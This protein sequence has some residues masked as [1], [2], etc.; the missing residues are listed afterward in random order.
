MSRRSPCDAAGL[1]ESI[2]DARGRTTVPR[3]V[4]DCIGAGPGVRLVWHVTPTGALSVR[5]KARVAG[6]PLLQFPANALARPLEHFLLECA[7]RGHSQE[8][9]VLFL[10]AAAGDNRAHV[11]NALVLSG[12]LRLALA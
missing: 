6:F 7:G 8:S 2:L 11:R 1:S 12:A 9:G 10:R 4:R 5:A 3:K